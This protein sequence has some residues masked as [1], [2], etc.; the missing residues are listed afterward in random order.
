MINPPVKKFWGSWVGGWVAGICHLVDVLFRDSSL[1]WRSYQCIHS[2]TS[3]NTSKTKPSRSVNPWTHVSD[4]CGVAESLTLRGQRCKSSLTKEFW[5][6][7]L[8]SLSLHTCTH[9]LYD[10]LMTTHP[11]SLHITSSLKGFPLIKLF[12][13]RVIQH[14]SKHLAYIFMYKLN[15]LANMITFL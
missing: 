8:S 5:I 15:E 12:I 11:S 3:S 6:L 7:S 10:F 14:V 1:S 13:Q 4:Q 2:R 9:A